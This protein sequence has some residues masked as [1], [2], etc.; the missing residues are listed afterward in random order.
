MSVISYRAPGPVASRF[1]RSSARRR[2]IM[3]PF[4][5]GKSVACCVEIMRRAREQAPTQDGVRR[6]RWAVVRN[7]YPDLKNTTVKTWR[8]WWGDDFGVFSRVAPFVHHMKFP[9]DDGTRVDCEVIFLA[10]DDEADAKKFLSLELTGIYFNEVRELKRAVVEAGDGRL[11]RY[12]SMK[13]GGP[14]WYGMIADVVVSWTNYAL[15]NTGACARLRLT[16][17]LTG[18]TVLTFP[19]YQ[20]FLSVDNA[21][22]HT[23]TIKCAGGTGVA[24][25]NG[26]KAVLYCDGVDY[27]NAGPTVLGSGNVTMTGNL[28]LSGQISGVAPATSGTQAVNKTQMETA[29]A[30]A[31]LPATAGTVLVNSSDTTA[32]YLAQKVVGVGAANVSVAGVPGNGSIVVAVGV[33]GLADGGTQNTGFTAATNTLYNCAFG[34][35]GEIVGPPAPTV[36]DLIGLSLAGHYVYLFN[37]N[38]LRINSLT[39]AFPLLGNQT[40]LLRY[41]GATDGWV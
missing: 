23:V 17:A 25:P 37:P 6:T 41:T 28:T 10:M 1:L 19:S 4:G 2:V 36:G 39:N 16:G 31:A 33:L 9:L 24:I 40:V 12:P 27:Y 35:N 32:G 21:A 15:A 7:T 14:S 13:D 30:T 22:G 20:N 29:I 18:P 34:A 38:G 5:S 8:D 3:G 26:A 11:G